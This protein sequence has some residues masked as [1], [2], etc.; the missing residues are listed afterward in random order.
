[1]RTLDVSGENPRL[2]VF[3]LAGNTANMKLTIA[4]EEEELF[5][6]EE[7]AVSETH[8]STTAGTSVASPLDWHEI[9]PTMPLVTR[10]TSWATTRNNNEET[11]SPHPINVETG[12]QNYL[13]H[14][15]AD[16]LVMGDVEQEEDEEGDSD[17]MCDADKIKCLEEALEESIWDCL[18]IL[19][20]QDQVEEA[21]I[22]CESD[23]FVLE[24][25]IASYRYIASESAQ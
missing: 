1:V 2:I 22:D 15:G 19:L 21:A 12:P 20:N 7:V 25:G 6:P 4:D 10:P 5:T 14:T 8:D 13:H 18:Q 17:S 3:I 23:K 9:F 11:S 16:W 24:K